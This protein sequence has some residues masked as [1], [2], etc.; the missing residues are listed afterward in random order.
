M[1]T[2]APKTD[3]PK[4]R[5][6]RATSYDVYRQDA[7]GTLDLVAADVKAPTRREAI[8]KAT[9]DLDE[10]RQYGTFCTVKHGELQSI[11]RARKVEPQDVWS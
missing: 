5:K 3:T 6:P 2:D 1:S 9:A 4:P 10:N 8:V 7:D 11:T